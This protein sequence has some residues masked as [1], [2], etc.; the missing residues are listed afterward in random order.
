MSESDTPDLAA[1]ATRRRR[2]AERAFFLPVLGMVL[3]LTPVVNAFASPRTF[4]GMP[5]SFL[6]IFGVWA[7]L[8][9]L[10]RRLSKALSERADGT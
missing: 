4:L 8:I 7:F 10:A 9:V 1:E 3:L 2:V 5:L 6:Y